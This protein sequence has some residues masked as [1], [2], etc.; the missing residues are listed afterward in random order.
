MAL[1]DPAMHNWTESQPHILHTI[2][3]AIGAVIV[4]AIGKWLLRRNAQENVSAA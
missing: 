1:T 3:P 4:V 2:V